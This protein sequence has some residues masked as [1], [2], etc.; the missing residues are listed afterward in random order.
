[1]TRENIKNK[2]NNIYINQNHVEYAPAAVLADNTCLLPEVGT[3]LD[4]ACGLGG[5]ALLLAKK[6]L[7]TSAWDISSVAIEQLA[8]ISAS[9]QKV[10]DAQ[11]VNV[12]PAIFSPHSFDVIVVSRYLDRIINEAILLALKP[13]G[14][15]FYQ[16]FNINKVSPVGPKNPDYLLRDNELLEIFAPLDVVYYRNNAAIGDTTE[17]FRNEAQFIGQKPKSSES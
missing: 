9:Q 4:L 11:V 15:L 10:I 17:G 8:L 6:G 1:M 16:T 13:G 5:N 14:L 12:T 3:A 7:Q 2:W